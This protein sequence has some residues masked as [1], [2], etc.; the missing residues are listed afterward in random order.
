MPPGD[1]MRTRMLWRRKGPYREM[2]LDQSLDIPGE[3]G[4]II[5]GGITMSDI[6]A[7]AVPSAWQTMDTQR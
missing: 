2:F 6:D 1:Q 3:D 4:H 7:N 5:G